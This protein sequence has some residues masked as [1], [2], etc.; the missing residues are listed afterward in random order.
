MTAIPGP[1]YNTYHL[2]W[3]HLLTYV[4]RAAINIAEQVSMEQHVKSFGHV[5][6]SGTAGW[7]GKIYSL[8]NSYIVYYI[9]VSIT[10]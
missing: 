5:P 4:T 2:N 6:K 8:L 9:S 10:F 1:S 7:Y 3:F